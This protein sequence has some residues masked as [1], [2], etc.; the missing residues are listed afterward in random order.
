M[1]CPLAPA[2]EYDRTVRVRRRCG[3]TSNYFAT[4]SFW[5]TVCKTVRPMLSGHCPVLSITLVYCAMEVG[6]GPSHIVLYGDPA[7]PTERGTASPLLKFKGAGFACVRIIRG[8]CQRLRFVS[9]PQIRS[10]ILALHKLVCMY[11][12]MYVFWPN[13]WMDQDA[14]W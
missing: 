6:L 13:G 2:D 5:A 3:L 8:P 11:V 12:C 7:P 14:S 10:T 4:C 1:G 9:A